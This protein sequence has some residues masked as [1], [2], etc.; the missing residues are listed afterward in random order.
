M[1]VS[2]TNLI[3]IDLEMTGLNPDRDCILEIATMVT[4]ENLSIIASGPVFAI[5]Q[6]ENVLATMDAWNTEHHTASGLISRVRESKVNESRAEI[7][8]INFLKNFVPE[9]V[10]PMCGNTIYQDRR[11]LARYMPML[12]RYFHYRHIDV[13]TIKELAKRWAPL[14]YQGFKKESKHLAL[15]DIK[16]SIAELM[17][18]KPALF[19]EQKS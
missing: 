7:E 14:L 4:D 2:A 3:W 16:E 19:S 9:G 17:H 6:E 11:F 13:S 12:E 18:Y 8:T 10:S 15:E 1:S 5:H